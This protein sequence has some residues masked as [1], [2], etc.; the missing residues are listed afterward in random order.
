[1]DNLENEVT[2]VEDTSKN[3]EDDSPRMLGIFPKPVYFT[4]IGRSFTEEELTYMK[5]LEDE[6]RPNEGN[7][8]SSNH[9]ILQKP[10]MED[11]NN[12]ITK[13]VNNFLKQLY[14]HTYPVEAYVTQSWL[15][16]TK[17]GQWHHKHNHS[18]SFLESTASL[19]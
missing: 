11:I 10:L 7:T 5:E 16:Y 13:E 14:A 8:T 3:N 18:N 19:W 6:C 1:M 17:K 9:Y 12:I 2:D 4:N 15:N